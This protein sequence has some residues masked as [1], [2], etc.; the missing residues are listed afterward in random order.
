M[1]EDA[2][3]VMT[4]QSAGW[5]STRVLRGCH[6]RSPS[7]FECVVSTGKSGAPTSMLVAH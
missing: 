6:S 2:I 1:Q 4:H 5:L 7:G 3:V